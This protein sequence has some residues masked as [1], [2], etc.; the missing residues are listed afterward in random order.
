MSRIIN[1]LFEITSAA[2]MSMMFC[3]APIV[4]AE[5][6]TISTPFDHTSS[7]PFDHTRTGFVLRDVHTTLR[8][9]QC[10]VDGIFKNTPKDCAGCHAIG[11][12]VGATPK[13]INHVQT[14]SP[15][16]TCHV[17]ATSFLVKSFKH[18]GVSGGCSSCHNGQSLGVVSKPANHFPTLL[19]CESCHNNTNTFTSARM[20]HAG[21]TSNCASCHGGQFVGVVSKPMAH[22]AT[23]TA[24]CG[25]CHNT[26]TF[27]G[28][29]F[30]HST[31]TV[32]GKCDTC[33]MGQLTGV[34]SKPAIHITTGSANC[35]ACHTAAN[36]SGY[37]S[38]AGGN[39]NH[40][41]MVSPAAANNCSSCHTGRFP[42]VQGKPAYH[43]VTAAQCDTCHTSANTSNYTTFFGATFSHAAIGATTC[44]SCHNG[45]AAKGKSAVHIPTTAACDTCHSNFT[46]FLGAM[47]HPGNITPGVCSTCHNGVYAAGKP[48]THIF[49][50]ATCDKCHTQTNT[51]NYTTFLGAGFDHAS[52]GTAT[53]A[54]CHNGSAAT[55]K[56]SFH[57][58][59][60][61]DCVTCHTALNTNNYKSFLGATYIHPNPPGVCSTCHNGVNAKGKSATHISTAA[62]CDTCHTKTNT[63][64]YTSFLGATYHLSVLTPGVCSTCHNGVSAL[65]KPATH[66][67]T[68]AACDTCHTKTNTSSYTTFLGASYI[69]ASPPGVCSTCHNGVTAM[70]KPALHVATAAAC[71][72]C[73]TKTNTANY[74]TFLGAVYVHLTPPGVCSSCHNGV[75]ALGKP[76]WHMVT[77]AACDSCHTQT[78]TSN[79]TTFLGA[80]GMVDHSTIAAG[81][82][83]TCHNG[84]TAKGKTAGHIPVSISCDGC[85]QKYNGTT[86]TTFAPATMNHTLVT[87]TSCYSCHNGSYA[88]QG[89]MGAKAMVTNHIPT[90]ITGGTGGLPC[91]T[92]HTNPIYTSASGWASEKMNH[93]GAKGGGVPVYCVTCH[94]SGTTYMGSMDK[95]SHNGASTAKDCSSS[96]CHKPLGKEGTAYI[97]W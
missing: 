42:G 78:N 29:R 79:Y 3:F 24:D 19:P 90:A 30:D 2:L 91:T 72:L 94:L 22:I 43:I 23:G 27:N 88:T 71:D 57:I 21:I 73:H 80:T 64:T 82:C 40:A 77:T 49:T 10:H 18:A 52:I 89:T 16:D 33:H 5:P 25:V 74:T 28:A 60:T 53:C 12:R 34:V 44:A 20:D 31:G 13:P 87:G 61:A 41:S 51:A 35:D 55:G 4:Q 69:H 76:S 86:V 83:A 85:H 45:V 46:S 65:G 14:T 63:A 58:A 68:T 6:V 62:A 56:P 70:G 17:S 1:K 37:T 48:N 84:T 39:Y 36:T 9:E 96:N 50:T 26:T 7:T 66:V 67:A 81:T 54:S 11:S 92:C 47:Y 8:C 15:C 32:S 97:S 95:K 59:T 38:F 75:T 93:N